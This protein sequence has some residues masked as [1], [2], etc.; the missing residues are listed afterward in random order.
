MEFF[1]TKTKNGIPVYFMQL[2]GLKSV[3]CGALVNVGSRDEKNDQFGIAHALEHMPFKGTKKFSDSLSLQSYI[4]EV[5][6]FINAVTNKDRT[7]F[8]S[9]VPD[10]EIERSINWLYEVLEQPLLREA[11]WESEKKV[12]IEE[13]KKNNDN[14]NSYFFNLVMGNLFSSHPISH[15]VVGN[16]QSVSNLSISDLISFKTKF[17]NSS[18]YVFF[19]AGNI[20]SQKTLDLFEKYFGQLKSGQKNNK[21]VAA[22]IKPDKKIFIGNKDFNQTKFDLSFFIDQISFDEKLALDFFTSMLNGGGASPLFQELRVKRNLIY[23]VG[24][25]Y[26]PGLDVGYFSVSMSTTSQKYEEINKLVL[27]IIDQTKEDE[28]RFKKTKSRALGALAFSFESPFNIISSAANE[29]VYFGKP[30]GYK[31]YE[32]KIKNLTIGEIKKVVEKYLNQQNAYLNILLP[33]K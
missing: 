27:S 1:E 19:V 11:D 3:A 4:E 29:M 32:E 18:N 7:F 26:Y 16:E 5:G 20:D 2:S 22:L 31:E 8:Y 15:P 33:K 28:E 13:I 17:Y 6:G 25:S 12:I 23:S 10:Y 9:K 21:R 24:T 14:P 30:I